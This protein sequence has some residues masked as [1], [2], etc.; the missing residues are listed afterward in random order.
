MKIF[1]CFTYFDEEIILDLRLKTLDKYVDYFVIVESLFN[2]RGQKRELK[3][4]IEKFKKFKKKIIYLVH[5]K[6]SSKIK[7]INPRDSLEKK[8]ID[9]KKNAYLR[10]S[11][12]RDF[13]SKGLSKAKENDLIMI[14]DVDEVPNLKNLRLDKIKKKIIFFKQDMYYYKFNLKLP[15]FK[16]FGTK[17]CKKKDLV[18]PQWLRL[19]KNKKYPFYRVDTLFTQKKYTSVQ[20]VD[21]GGWHFT[22]IKN[23][24]NIKIKLKS[25]LHHR[26]FDLNPLSTQEI[27]KI[28]KKRIAIYNL[29]VDKRFNKIGNG[30]KLIKQN[31]NKLPLYLQKNI[32]K[33]RKWID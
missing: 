16:W 33:Y 8:S 30:S 10:E 19:I 12:Q 24:K 26:E 22:N 1:D 3:F 29:N 17:A 32:T 11:G 9:Y 25:Y 2:H 7:A 28:I 4:N 14:S 21:K 13:I 15:N 20:F 31:I 5:K 23:A 6:V 27:N 18:S